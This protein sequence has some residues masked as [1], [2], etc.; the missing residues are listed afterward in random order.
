MIRFDK[1]TQKAQ[2]AVQR[3][4]SLAAEASHQQVFPL[5]LLVALAEEQEGVPA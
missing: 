3:A 5:H 4:Q 1:F 2:E